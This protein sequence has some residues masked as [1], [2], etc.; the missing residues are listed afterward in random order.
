MK[1]KDIPSK[2]KMVLGALLHDIGK[3]KQR[4]ALEEDNGSTHV[5]IRI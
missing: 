4:A 2:T 3:F 1:M 5:Q